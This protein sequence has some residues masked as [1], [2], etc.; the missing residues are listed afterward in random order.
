MLNIK[1][2]I[3]Q[4]HDNA[5][6]KGFYDVPYRNISE[7]LM[8]IVSEIAEAQEALRKNK[9]LLSDFNFDKI[10]CYGELNYIIFKDQIKDT[11]ED[12][13]ADAFIRLADLCG[14][15]NIDIEKF[16]QAKMEYNK[17]RIEKHG[18]EF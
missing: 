9:I 8:L 11:F 1:D 3:K 12:E 15:L 10:Y 13:I 7:I 16:I 5:V 17:M 6:E 14:Y 2:L 18:K 4:A